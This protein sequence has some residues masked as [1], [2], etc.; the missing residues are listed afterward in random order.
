MRCNER[1][2]AVEHEGQSKPRLRRSPT[3]G[4]LPHGGVWEPI[5]QLK[6]SPQARNQIIC[7]PAC[8]SS[9]P[10]A[11]VKH[12][13][14]LVPTRLAN[15]IAPALRVTLAL[16]REIN[17]AAMMHELPTQSLVLMPTP[18]SSSLR[19]HPVP[20]RCAATSP[21]PDKQRSASVLLYICTPFSGLPFI[22]FLASSVSSIPSVLRGPNQ[23]WLVFVLVGH[24]LGRCRI[25]VIS[26]HSNTWGP[27]QRTLLSYQSLTIL[28]TT[29]RKYLLRTPGTAPTMPI[30]QRRPATLG[31]RQNTS[32]RNS[33]ESSEALK[34]QVVIVGDHYDKPH[35]EMD[36]PSAKL[37]SM[38]TTPES[39]NKLRIN[40]YSKT[41][42]H[43]RYMSSE[44]EPS[45]SPDEEES[46]DEELKHKP[47]IRFTNGYDDIWTA[48]E[49]K[50]A[51]AIA[52]PILSVGRPK[53]VDITNLAP[54]KRKQRIPKSQMSHTALKITAACIPAAADENTAFP[55]N[56]AAE[57]RTPPTMIRPP[58]APRRKGSKP[59]LT[60]P[61][62]W[63]PSEEAL[64]SHDEHY[65]PELDVRRAPSYHY[66]DPYSL[67]PPRLLASGKVSRA[68]ESSGSASGNISTWRGLT[69]TLSLAKKQNPHQ[70]KKPKMFA[71]G[72]NERDD[73]LVIPPFPFKSG[74]AWVR[75]ERQSCLETW[76]DIIIAA[77]DIE[78]YW[79]LGLDD[80]L[81]S[82]PR[83][84]T[85]ASH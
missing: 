67:D 16:E 37:G 12:W 24:V 7:Q 49:G 74:V 14:S 32:A 42:L 52:V 78:R 41:E 59:V 1:R 13:T 28:W 31:S 9:P 10:A 35:K 15:A 38:L 55:A 21:F 20:A 17:S 75:C 4:A 26:L 64:Q 5:S 58:Q 81:P 70:T 22:S 60:A 56:E 65:F 80:P 39:G 62:S 27:A 45:P 25:I 54:M 71:R 33:T 84:W 3:S 72:A 79:S 40:T 82:R 66:Y 34:E 44:E 8:P 83:S 46:N 6:H 69:R 11:I 48:S 51:I 18:W 19:A 73:M 77:D 43:D 57:V 53:L 36:F 2:S 61:D 23:V 76:D 29:S 47:S 68:R 85:A 50:A 30:L 63:L